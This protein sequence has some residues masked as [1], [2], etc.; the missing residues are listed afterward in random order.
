M[1]DKLYLILHKT[2]LLDRLLAKTTF[3]ANDCWMCYAGGLSSRY[4]TIWFNGE[5]LSCHHASW[6]L[7]KG[8]IPIGFHV[9]HSCDV[10]RC[11]NPSHLFLGT[12]QDNMQDKHFKGR[13]DPRPGEL[14]PYAVLTEDK[15]ITIRQMYQEGQR[16]QD[17]ADFFG[18]SQSVISNICNYKT[19][20]HVL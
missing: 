17:I 14:N 10:K 15:V 18:V 19:W 9:L 4:G 16:Q 8:V 12:P 20:S 6:L 7:F 11:I 5:N 3:T 1:S 2:G 13:N